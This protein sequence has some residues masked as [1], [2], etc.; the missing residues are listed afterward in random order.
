M[1]EVL[2][3]SLD[4]DRRARAHL[5]VAVAL[6]ASPGRDEAVAETAHHR[7]SA[8]PLGSAEAAAES[9]RRAAARAMALLAFE[10]AASLLERAREAL[11]A[12]PA[13]GDEHT[14]C[15]LTLLAGLARMRAGDLERGRRTCL[16]AADH[17]RRMGAGDLLARSA[18]GYGSELILAVTDASLVGLLEEAL[19]MLPAGPSGLRAQCLARLAAALQPAPDPWAPLVQAREAVTMARALGDEEVLRSVLAAAGSA[20]ADYAPPVERAAVSEELARLATAAG[21]RVLVLR[22]QARLVIDYL[23]MGALDR[24]ARAVDAYEALAREIRQVRH[25]WPGRLMRAMLASATGRFEEAERLAEEARSLAPEDDAMAGVTHTWRRVAHA[26]LSD[27][28]QDL[29]LAERALPAL[30]EIPMFSAY[31]D[32]FVNLSLAAIRARSGDRDSARRHLAAVAITSHFYLHEFSVMTAIAEAIVLTENRELAALVH[33]RLEPA[34]RPVASGGRVGLSCWGLVDGARAMLAAFLGRP[35]EARAHFEAASSVATS[36]G[37][38]PLLA[39]LQ[40]RYSELLRSQGDPE[41]RA[42]AESLASEAR[43]H[44]DELGLSGLLARL[45]RSAA[46]AGPPP[47]E[48]PPP[49]RPVHGPDFALTREGEYWTVAGA[50]GVCRVKDG[51][52]IQMLAQLCAHPGQEFHVLALMGATGDEAADSGD[53]GA[54]LDEEAVA[55]YRARVAELDEELAEAQ[56]WAD[57]GRA[58]RLRSE[59]EAVAA[60]L[61]RGVGLG[62]RARRSGSA[63]ERARTNVQ[64]R[65]RRS[66]QKIGETLP[67]LGAYLDRAVKTGTFCSYEPF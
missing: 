22:A 15:E 43:I 44:A 30:L 10:D 60:E 52:G 57:T 48:A 45:T 58:E 56:A 27:R 67:A 54:L 28:D 23:E 51:R 32:D 3:R 21:D 31:A 37:L 49:P 53:A 11:S 2:Y 46:A 42:R 9:A 13:P 14:L 64:R 12:L 63:A 24:S 17:A 20:M 7:L 62:G 41:D 29:A 61:S 66:I 8:L 39:R 33:D 1:R 40:Y 36:A 26:L 35:A 38:R 25:L 5:A 6:E 34:Q 50:G 4:A 59:R 19:A 65:I 16:E 47:V 55:E 18:L